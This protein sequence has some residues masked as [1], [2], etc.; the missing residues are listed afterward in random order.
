M[1]SRWPILSSF[2]ADEGLLFIDLY[3]TDMILK[4]YPDVSEAMAALICKLVAATRIG[5]MCL[6]IDEDQIFPYSKEIVESLEIAEKMDAMALEGLKESN[7]SLFYEEQS[8]LLQGYPLVK[9]GN[10]I[11]LQK[12]AFFERRFAFELQR[13]SQQARIEDSVPCTMALE[14]LNEEQRQAVYLSRT[15]TFSIITGGPGTGKTY[16][17]AQIV[18]SFIEDTKAQCVG[19]TSIVLT[20]PTGKAAAHLEKNV[21]KYLD[22][23]KNI[24]SGTIHLLLSI[25]S[26]SDMMKKPLPLSAD[27]VIVDEA[28]MID[29]RLFS[30]LLAS[31]QKGCRVVIMGD[32]D[33]LPPVENGSLFADLVTFSLKTNSFAI[34]ELKQCLR[35][36]I[37]QIVNLAKAINSSDEEYVMKSLSEKNEGFLQRKDFFS[38]SSVK[39]AYEKLWQFCQPFF[40]KPDHGLECPEK[41]LQAFDKFR[42]L[43]CTRKGA[44]GV[45]ALNKFISQKMSMEVSEGQLIAEP[46]LITKNDYDLGLFNGDVGVL[47]HK[48]QKNSRVLCPEDAAYFFD[49]NSSS[50]KKYPALVLPSF[51]FAYC[52]SVHKSQGSEYESVLIL[53][54]E[55]AASFGKEI[56]YTA[57]TRAKKN[58]Y[59]DISDEMISKLVNRSSR[60]ISGLH[61]RLQLTGGDPCLAA[62]LYF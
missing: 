5:H 49:K 16:T 3:I 17:A 45:D 31:I 30:Y 6:A 59:L 39:K 34:T 40:P 1:F 50:L 14:N 19:S 18:R 4:P 21:C 23:N 9:N 37:H 2:V 10:Y 57:V 35:S 51:E 56:L 55:A 29:A 38:S 60:K 42:I 26:S 12:N 15:H 24:R 47:A 53:A 62:S 20:A 28:S 52:L 36:D 61:A 27:L 58:V 22:Q 25:K 46:I 32:R 41:V 48:R 43:G 54:P 8:A 7:L 44:F 33:Q 11:Y 13:L